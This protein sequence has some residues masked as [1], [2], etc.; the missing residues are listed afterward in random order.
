MQVFADAEQS[1]AM[2]LILHCQ[3]SDHIAY[4]VA[5]RMNAVFLQIFSLRLLTADSM[6]I[7]CRFLV[8][9]NK[10]AGSWQIC[11]SGPAV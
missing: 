2:N 8:N 1:S 6:Q 9:V 7:A 3:G 5:G 4:A 10:K 11:F